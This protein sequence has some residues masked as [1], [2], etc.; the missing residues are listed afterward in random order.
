MIYRIKKVKII[1]ALYANVT[2]LQGR[3]GYNAGTAIL[4]L[5]IKNN[6]DLLDPQGFPPPEAWPLMKTPS[7]MGQHRLPNSL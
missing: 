2:D 6:G 3:K 7:P 4:L 5:E 1:R